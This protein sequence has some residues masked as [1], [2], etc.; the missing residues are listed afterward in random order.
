MSKL[1]AKFEYCIF[2]GFIGKS[3]L[4]MKEWFSDKLATIEELSCSYSSSRKYWENIIP[5]I[6]TSRYDVSDEEGEHFEANNLRRRMI[7]NN[8]PKSNDNIKRISW[9]SSFLKRNNRFVFKKNDSDD[10]YVKLS[11]S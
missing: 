1:S 3:Y 8:T 7:H 5:N 4:S 11:Y 6:N 9:I 10:R 2:L